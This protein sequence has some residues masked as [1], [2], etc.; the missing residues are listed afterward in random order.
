LD[1][2]R[3]YVFERSL[4]IHR[5]EEMASGWIENKKHLKVEGNVGV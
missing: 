4:A 1:R 2:L 3:C 5:Q